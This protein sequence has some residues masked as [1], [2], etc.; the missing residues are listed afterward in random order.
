MEVAKM[1]AARMETGIGL[2]P[3][4]IAAIKEEMDNSKQLQEEKNYQENVP[5]PIKT[6]KISS[7]LRSMIR[8]RWHTSLIRAS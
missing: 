1:R 7:I 3:D 2:Q 8:A 5:R 4:E 6:I